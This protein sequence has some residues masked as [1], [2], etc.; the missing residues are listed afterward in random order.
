M[1]FSKIWKFRKFIMSCMLWSIFRFQIFKF[2]M[3]THVCGVARGFR[4][5][6]C[7]ALSVM[8]CL[9]AAEGQISSLYAQKQKSVLFGP[10]ESSFSELRPLQMMS[11]CKNLDLN[12]NFHMNSILASDS[13]YFQVSAS[14]HQ[15]FIRMI[16]GRQKS[17]SR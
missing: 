17:I 15:L 10:C 1:K 3:L 2:P 7:E 12:M 5:T 8:M 4:L 13:I 6:W 16:P 9:G 11:S 14:E